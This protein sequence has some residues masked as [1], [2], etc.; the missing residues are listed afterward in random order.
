M[1]KIPV[2]QAVGMTLCH[3]ITAIRNGFKGAAYRRGHVIL[4][5]DVEKLKDIGKKHI[6]VWEENAG[7]IHEEDAALRLSRLCAVEKGVYS[8]PSE[9]KMVQTAGIRGMFRVNVD[10]QRAINS[11]GDITI[12][13]IPDHYPVEPGDRLCSMRIVPLVTQES[14]IQEAERLC[15]DSDRPLMELLPYRPLRVGVIITGSEVYTGRIQ[16]LFAPVIRKKIDAFGGEV[17]GVTFCDDE[18]PMLEDALRK[19]LDS[20]ADLILMTGGMSVDPDDLTPTAIK[21]IG[22]DIVT[23]GMPSQPGNMLL[24]SY[25][26]KTC[27]VGVPGAAAKVKTTTLDVVLPQ[28]FAGVPFTK[29]DF[30]R[31]GDGGFCQGCS[32]CHWPNCTFGRY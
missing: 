24:V 19:Y 14:Q 9:G 18:L 15:R 7:E 17:L 23:Y 11:I 13:S 29:E 5:E 21:N 6:F 12:S 28:I 27:I 30:I 8:G 16:D 22:A 20:G 26:G 2:E 1:K 25:L 31:L 4:P 32:V 3:D 10:L